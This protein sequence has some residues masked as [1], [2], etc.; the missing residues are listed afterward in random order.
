MQNME[1]YCRDDWS[2]FHTTIPGQRLFQGKEKPFSIK[3][4]NNRYRHAFARFR[5]KTLANLCLLEMIDITIR[6]FS[7]IHVNTTL[8]FDW[9]IFG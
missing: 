5:P 2:S 1:K 9:A 8:K 6:I 7:A 4:K 3:E